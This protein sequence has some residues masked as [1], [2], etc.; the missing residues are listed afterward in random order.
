[1]Q[2][3]DA[4]GMIL[5]ESRPHAD[6]MRK[7][8]VVYDGFAAGRQVRYTDI[9]AMLDMAAGKRVFAALRERDHAAFLDMVE[10]LA[11]EVDRHA[12]ITTR[13]A[14]QDVRLPGFAPR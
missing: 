7:A 13:T 8:S 11:R 9:L 2:L 14:A 12:P 1:M 6:L 10:T 4:A 3:K 5:A